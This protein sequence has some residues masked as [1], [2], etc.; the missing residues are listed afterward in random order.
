MSADAPWGRL[1]LLVLCYHLPHTHRSPSCHGRPLSQKSGVAYEAEWDATMSFCFT[2]K[3]HRC[4]CVLTSGF[5]STPH[6]L[7][8]IFSFSATHELLITVLAWNGGSHT[9]DGPKAA[10]DEIVVCLTAVYLYHLSSNDRRKDATTYSIAKLE[11]TY[12][13]ARM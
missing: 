3:T 7:R 8:V 13:V 6:W 10:R 1:R 5:L 12:C 2:R 11:A 4:P 9:V